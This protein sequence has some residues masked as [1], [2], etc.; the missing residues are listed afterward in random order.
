MVRNPAWAETCRI[1]PC[2]EENRV[3]FALFYEIPVPGKV[4]QDSYHKAVWRMVEEATLADRM[5]FHSFWTVEHHFTG[6]FST[7]SAPEVIYGNLAARTENMRIGHGVRLLPHAYNN[8]IRVAEQAAMVD[9]LSNGRLEFGTGRSATR[10]ELEGFG[11]DPNATREMQE[12]AL[13][14]I[15][16][17]WTEEEMEYDGKYWKMPRR[18]VCP[19][20]DQQP[21]PPIWQATTSPE[22]HVQVG[23]KG[24]GLLSFTIG[25]SPEMLGERIAGYHEGLTRCTKPVGKYVHDRVGAFTMVHCAPT[26]AEAK[27]EAAASFEWYGNNNGKLIADFSAWLSGTGGEQAVGAPQGTF[28]YINEYAKGAE[29]AGSGLSFDVMKADG[30]VIAGDPD[31]VIEVARRYEA[32]GC[33]LLM[34][35][36]NPYDIAH[37]KVMQSIELLGKHVIPEF[38]RE[39][40]SSRGKAPATV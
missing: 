19:K 10:T 37:D 40:W 29:H 27:E 5:G 24:L 30:A 33:Q 17:A 12:E 23:E 14:V 4:S 9:I 20:P 13:D 25:V 38:K 36:V 2:P 3:D 32:I 18:R 8:P 15:V 34:C 21:H 31:H 16:K 35:L 1:D 39:E 7:C 11:I 6:E 26:Q 22:G 28:D